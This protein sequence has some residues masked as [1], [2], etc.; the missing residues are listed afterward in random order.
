MLFALLRFIVTFSVHF[1]NV[2]EN[3]LT[4]I[5]CLAVIYYTHELRNHICA[6]QSMCVQYRHMKPTR[7]AIHS[8]LYSAKHLRN[9]I[10]FHSRLSSFVTQSKLDTLFDFVKCQNQGELWFTRLAIYIQTWRK[11]VTNAS[12]KIKRF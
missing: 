7:L 5:Y 9:R 2:I 6:C 10:R 11:N 3:A 12:S 4:I 8:T 1:N